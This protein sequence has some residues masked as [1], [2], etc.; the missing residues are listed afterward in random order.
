MISRKEA[1]I[2]FRISWDML[3]FVVSVCN[4]ILRQLFISLMLA[5][6]QFRK[7]LPRPYRIS[8]KKS[9]GGVTIPITILQE[10]T[11]FR[12]KLTT[13]FLTCNWNRNDEVH[14]KMKSSNWMFQFHIKQMEPATGWRMFPFHVWQDDLA[15]DFIHLVPEDAEFEVTHRAGCVVSVLPQMCQNTMWGFC[16]L[17]FGRLGLVLCLKTT[18]TS[19]MVVFTFESVF[20]LSCQEGQD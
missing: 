16:I 19:N 18:N 7:A 5:I 2:T 17:I 12:T 8:A 10:T 6:F 20:H 14:Q 11:K 9:G 4:T 3:G 1:L 13:W 15:E